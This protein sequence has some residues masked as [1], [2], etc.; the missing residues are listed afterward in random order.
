MKNF[1]TD[2]DKVTAK[3]MGLRTNEETKFDG[4]N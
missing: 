4:V 1:E 3:L 2:F